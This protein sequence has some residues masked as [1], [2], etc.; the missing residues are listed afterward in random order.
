MADTEQATQ[1]EQTDDPRAEAA[2]AVQRS[3]DRR[4]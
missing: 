1:T 2:R 3:L 4:G